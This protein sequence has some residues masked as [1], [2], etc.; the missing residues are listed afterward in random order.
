MPIVEIWQTKLP[1]LVDRTTSI[2]NNDSLSDM[3]F[4][5]PVSSTESKS[6]KVIP[7]QKFVLAIKSPVFFATFYGQMAET[8]DSIQLPNTRKKIYQ[9]SPGVTNILAVFP[10]IR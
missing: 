5:V 9:P 8:K 4:V 3:K 7:A 1:T 6:K 10:Q 2:F